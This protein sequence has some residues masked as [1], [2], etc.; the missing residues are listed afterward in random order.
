MQ[1]LPKKLFAHNLESSILREN[2]LVSAVVSIIVIRIFLR[3]TDYP[4]I[5]GDSLH[6]AHMLWGGLLMVIAFFLLFSYLSKKTTSL[7]A[8]I[9]GLGFGAFIDEIGKF[10]T[11]DNNYFFQPAI[12]IIYIIIVVLFLISQA[13]TRYSRSSKEEYLINALESV[14]EAVLND[15]DIEEKKVALSYLKASDQKNPLT[16]A[17]TEYLK[18]VESLPVRQQSFFTRVR[19][20]VSEFYRS[21][22][23]S[24]Y[25]TRTVAFILLF[26]S[27]TTAVISVNFM[28]NGS[29]LTFDELGKLISSL[30]SVALVVIGIALLRFSKRRAYR[31]FKLAIFVSIFFTQFFLLYTVDFLSFLTLGVNILLLLVVD[32]VILE[33]EREQQ[34]LITSSQ[35]S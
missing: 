16:V 24:V 7:A 18:S 19:H 3:L 20:H 31:S 29:Q 35:S 1:I 8:I 11:R 27:L 9:G 5:G 14:K 28:F 4:S 13:I 6:I 25:L 12:A 22:A 33:E 17:L 15:M 34:L 26:Q 2:F 30:A 23:Q 21:T 32:Y 10:I